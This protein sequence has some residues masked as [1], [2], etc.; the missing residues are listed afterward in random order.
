MALD[1]ILIGTRVRKVREELLGETREDFAKRCNLAPRYIG[2]IE[3]GE[4]LF[5][6]PVLDQ[7][8]SATGVETDY[9]L[10]GKGASKK[11]TIKKT[12]NNMIEKADTNEL[13]MYYKCLT[14]IKGYV[15]GEIKK[16]TRQQKNKEKNKE[17]N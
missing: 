7:I 3:R 4:F 11:L 1:K 8:A 12:L 2:Q 15:N 9:I 16:E 17:K 6:L 14:T 10:Y 13:V 5:S